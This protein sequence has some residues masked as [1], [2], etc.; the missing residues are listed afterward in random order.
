MHI[1][2]SLGGLAFLTTIVLEDIR[3]KKIALH[4]I[5]LF[6]IG[7]LLWRMVTN[8]FLC[9]AL[10]GSIMPGMVLLLLAFVSKESIG[11][12]D[13]LAVIVFGLW[14]GGLFALFVVCAGTI[15]AGVYGLVGLIAEKKETIPFIPFLLVGM[16]VVLFYA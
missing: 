3:E 1:I 6:G 14:T 12:G 15:L 16:E 5:L 13:G 8:T 2:G 4:K 7:A 10:L 9:S 11:Y